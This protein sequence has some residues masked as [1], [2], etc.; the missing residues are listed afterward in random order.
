MC[1]S[2]KTVV[3]NNMNYSK[4]MSVSKD[5]RKEKHELFKKCQSRKTVV[6]KNMNYAR[7]KMSV[8]NDRREENHEL[9]KTM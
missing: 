5:R 9:S 7:K 6:R 2:R 1:Q 4:K 3:R 8:S